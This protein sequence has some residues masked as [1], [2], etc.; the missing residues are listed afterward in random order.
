MIVFRDIGHLTATYS[1]SLAPVLD[2]EIRRVVH[3]GETSGV[4]PG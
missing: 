1:R 2:A 4:G 3:A